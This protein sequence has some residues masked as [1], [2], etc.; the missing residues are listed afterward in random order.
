MKIVVVCCILVKKNIFIGL[1]DGK[2]QA[3]YV[4][5]CCNTEH[6]FS[7]LYSD[8]SRVSTLLVLAALFSYQ[9]SFFIFWRML[10]H[11]RFEKLFNLESLLTSFLMLDN[12]SIFLSD[13]RS[14]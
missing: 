1:D 4:N 5:Y 10:M 14:Y 13:S 12:D 2:Y 8:M 11:L 9:G 6:I 3:E 7:F